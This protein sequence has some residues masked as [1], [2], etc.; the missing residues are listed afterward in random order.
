MQVQELDNR[1]SAG[2]GPTN[3]KE[4]LRWLGRALFGQYLI[5]KRFK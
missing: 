4:A 2:S 1:G 3:F 5:R